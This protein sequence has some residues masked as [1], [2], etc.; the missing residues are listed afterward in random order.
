MWLLRSMPPS[1]FSS[2]HYPCTPRTTLRL[3]KHNYDR[4]RALIARKR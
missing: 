3:R 2:L 4:T 1:P